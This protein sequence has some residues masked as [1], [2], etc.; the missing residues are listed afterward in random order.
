MYFGDVGRVMDTIENKNGKINITYYPTVN[1]Y[2]GRKT[3]QIV[4][5]N[6][7]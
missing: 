7:Q 3:L 4:I 6:Y 1:E 5:Q 2:M